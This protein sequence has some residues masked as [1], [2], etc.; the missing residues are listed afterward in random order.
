M[1][2]TITPTDANIVY[3]PGNWSVTSARAKTVNPGA[4]LRTLVADADET[5]TAITLHLALTGTSNDTDPATL[6]VRIDGSDWQRLPVA[7]TLTPTIPTYAAAWNRHLIEIVMDAHQSDKHGIWT[8]DDA[9]QITG[10]EV[11]TTGAITYPVQAR[12]LRGLVFGDSIVAGVNTLGLGDGPGDSNILDWSYLIGPM[13]DAEVGVVAWGGQGY[14]K[15]GTYAVPV[16]PDSMTSLWSPTA[17]DPGPTRDLTGY[18]FVLVAEGTNDGATD[19]ATMLTNVAAVFDTLISQCDP[20]TV[21]AAVRP[22]NG[23]GI[24]TTVSNLQAG[25]AAC[26]EPARVQ[27]IDTTGWWDTSQAADGLHPYGYA[28]AAQLAPHLAAQ[29]AGLLAAAA[30]PT[31]GTRWVMTSTGW[32]TV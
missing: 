17:T 16:L 20:T 24:P 13:L 31:E 4:Y 2:T 28:H 7:A 1:S 25:I 12:P 5:I 11:N 15:Q 3:S 23:S 10:I 14:G 6:A 21:I 9:V 30:G 19:E 26:S 32:V 29:V 22:F 18:D 8:C 27:W